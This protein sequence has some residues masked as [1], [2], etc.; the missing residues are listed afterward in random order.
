MDYFFMNDYVIVVNMRWTTF[1]HYA[2][3]QNIFT[4]M[5]QHF[6]NQLTFEQTSA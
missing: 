2:N 6:Y 5:D 1:S 3:R 4:E